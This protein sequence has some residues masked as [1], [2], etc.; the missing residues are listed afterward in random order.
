M[1]YHVSFRRPDGGEGSVPWKQFDLTEKH[2]LDFDIP[3]TQKTNLKAEMIEFW[4]KQ[5]PQIKLEHVEVK[6]RDEL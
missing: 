4:S 5:L 1:Y 3:I 6:N 2:Y